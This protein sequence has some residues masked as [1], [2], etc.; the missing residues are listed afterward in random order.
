[1]SRG[2]GPLRPLNSFDPSLEPG[3][4]SKE[5]EVVAG[6]WEGVLNEV[7]GAEG[8]LL[9]GRVPDAPVKLPRGDE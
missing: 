9:L 7:C 5:R 1:M 2:D 4:S 6:E 3:P 8:D